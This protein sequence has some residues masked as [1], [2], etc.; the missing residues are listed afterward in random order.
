[1]LGGLLVQ[2]IPTEEALP[3]AVYLHGLAADNIVERN[4]PAPVLATDIINDI[5]RLLGALEDQP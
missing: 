2:G 5:P 1:M 3:L 4:G